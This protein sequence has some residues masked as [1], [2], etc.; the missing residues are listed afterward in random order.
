VTVN[1]DP[2]RSLLFPQVP[3]SLA[4]SFTR[5]SLDGVTGVAAL[6]LPLLSEAGNWESWTN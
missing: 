2:H 6:H 5:R 4:T 1:V 3:T